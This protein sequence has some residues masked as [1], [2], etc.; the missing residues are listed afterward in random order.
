MTTR[1]QYLV[2]H[3]KS[4]RWYKPFPDAGALA[5]ILNRHGAQGWELVGVA[6]APPHAQHLL[7][8]RPG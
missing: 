4:D 3:A 6:G 1:W 8:K 5:E 7:F 2:V